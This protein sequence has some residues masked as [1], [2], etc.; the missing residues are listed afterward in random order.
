MKRTPDALTIVGVILLIVIGLTWIVPSGEFLREVKNIDGREITLVQAGTYQ[1]VAQQPQSFFS[2]LTA[3]IRGFESAADIIAFVLLVGGAF[4]MLMATGAIDSALQK[5]LTYAKKHPGNGTLVILMLMSVFALAGYSFGMSEETL[6]FVL[7]TLPLARSMGYDHFVGVAIPFVGAGVGFA[8][9]A[10]NPF[11]VG[12]A[13]GIAELPLFSGAAYRTAVCAVMVI[14][15]AWYVIRYAN[16]L[17][18][19]P[20]KRFMPSLDAVNE[21][22]QARPFNTQAK[23]ILLIFFLSLGL[24]VFGAIEWGWYIAEI[25]GLFIALGLLSAIIARMSVADTVKSFYTGAKEMLPAALIIALSKSILVVAND[26]KIVDTIL[27]AL[28]GLVDGMPKVI[29]VQLM[30][31]TQGAI[32]FFIPSGSGQA[33]ITIPIMSPLADLIGVSRQTAVLAYQFGDGLFN[34]IIPTSGVTMGILSIAK[35]PFGKWLRWIMPLMVILIVAA[36][37]FLALPVLFF[38]W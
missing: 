18:K 6:V 30:F 1:E 7:I 5:V 14:I 33:S 15:A 10:F 19:A 20:E 36:M 9:A 2:A 12:I 22:M 16:R 21:E 26:G 27:F 8:G 29:A 17:L 34:M 38:S 35:I 25:S 4:S 13:H 37:I 32:N 24:V 28:S 3:P 31:L 11:T 23:I